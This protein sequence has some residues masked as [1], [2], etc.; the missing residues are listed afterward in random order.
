MHFAKVA[1]LSTVLFAFGHR[2]GAQHFAAGFRGGLGYTIN[3]N[4]SK[5]GLR[6]AAGDHLYSVPEAFV[7]YST[8]KRWAFEVSCDRISHQEAWTYT[9]IFDAPYRTQ[10]DVIT[11]R[12]VECTLSVQYELLDSLRK[13]H[14]KLAPFHSY[15]GFANTASRV[16]MNTDYY[17]SD[18]VRQPVPND[19]RAENPRWQIWTGFSHTLIRDF[20]PR[21]SALWTVN[22]RANMESLLGSSPIAYLRDPSI[23]CS[24]AL[25]ALYRF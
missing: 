17:Y 15:A 8:K 9:G 6:T 21:L 3:G 1:L 23:R 24:T 22:V 12:N 18:F 20:G 10:T 19:S 11:V 2:S 16:F 4:L 5:G 14:K 25:G 7:R 13:R